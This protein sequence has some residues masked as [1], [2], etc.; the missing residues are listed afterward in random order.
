MKKRI[1]ITEAASEC[2]LR[3]G[4]AETS[5]EEIVAES[6]VVKQTIYNYFSNKDDLFKAAIEHLLHATR[7]E[8]DSN[9]YQLP[10]EKFFATLAEH[11][12]RTLAQKRTTDFLRLLV[13]ECRRYPELQH[14]Y[15]ESIP[16]PFVNFVAGYIERKQAYSGEIDAHALA[17]CF[18]AALTG[19]ATLLN[20]GALVAAPLPSPVRFIQVLSFLFAKF[21]ELEKNRSSELET[22]ERKFFGIEEFLVSA[23]APLAS[24]RLSILVAAVKVFSEKGY[25]ESSM[26]EVALRASV[27]KQTVYKH[28]GN[29]N[30]LYISLA[31]SLIAK[32]QD[33]TLPDQSLSMLEYIQQLAGLL[34]E[35]S[36][37]PWLR[38]YFRCVFGESQVFPLPSGRL[39]LYLMHFG[40]AGLGAKIKET[41]KLSDSE[42]EP[43]ILILRCIIGA[44]VLFS[45]IY[46]L[47]DNPYLNQKSLL[48]IIYALLESFEK[49]R[50]DYPP[51]TGIQLK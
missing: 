19:Y 50:P 49:V 42:S 22:K 34:S 20:L 51:D 24:K 27:S 39:L 12:L 9:W 33:S 30:Q 11:Q 26:D 45:Q 21:L 15:A 18:R 35:Q 46:V 25:A 47:G 1:T 38:E 36:E 13:K 7:S 28:F 5:L 2:F 32:L 16:M 41:Y 17:W 4:Y 3:L 23:E 43:L 6:G 10:P 14:I 40:H 48:K 37:E 44:F 31:D 29:K 8:F